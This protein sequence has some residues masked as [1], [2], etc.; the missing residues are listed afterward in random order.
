MRYS[1][2]DLANLG[3][4]CAR[5]GV[6]AIQFVGWSVG[7]QDRGNPSENIDPRLGTW[8]ELHDAI[9][10]VQAKGVKIVLFGKY[11][12]ADMTTRWY[13]SDLYKYD[14]KDPYGIPYQ[15][16]GYSYDTPEQ[17]AAINNRRFAIM[18]FLDPA[19]RQV[20]EGQFKKVTAV[21]AA[22]FLYDEVCHH[23]V[24]RYCFATDHG[25]PTANTA[26]AFCTL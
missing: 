5:N 19:Y 13:R 1:Y 9:A 14:V 18:C 16:G 2:R 26:K 25:H 12:W 11:N 4:D 22:G 23:G 7:G 21:G 17:L 20:A 10:Q 15:H 3:E 24:A 6:R 8:Q